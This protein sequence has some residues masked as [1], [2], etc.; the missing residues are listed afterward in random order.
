M[1]TYVCLRKTLT[2]AE[3]G[4]SNQQ[5]AIK[6]QHRS[7]IFPTMIA[8]YVL[9]KLYDG[10]FQFSNKMSGTYNY[11]SL[12]KLYVFLIYSYW[13]FYCLSWFSYIIVSWFFFLRSAILLQK[14]GFYLRR[15]IKYIIKNP[16][17][18]SVLFAAKCWNCQN[19]STVGYTHFT[20][21]RPPFFLWTFTWH[22]QLFRM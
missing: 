11:M 19:V 4:K 18:F 12:L 17:A 20:R 1:A 10:S 9:W 15:I 16:Y 5:T 6:C 22:F 7:G 13:F 3:F 8:Q 2:Y 21:S 14:M